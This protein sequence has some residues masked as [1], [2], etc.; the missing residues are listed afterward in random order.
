MVE[1][2][3]TPQKAPLKRTKTI[4]INRKDQDMLSIR[5]DNTTCASRTLKTVTGADIERTHDR[6]YKIIVNTFPNK[7]ISVQISAEMW[8]Y[9]RSIGFEGDLTL[10]QV[11]KEQLET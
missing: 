10:E 4:E 2:A 9:L 11:V 7:V 1:F 3:T 6:A 8:K 5:Q